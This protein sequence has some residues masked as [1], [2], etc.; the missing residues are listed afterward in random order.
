MTIHQLHYALY[1]S[2]A[3]ALEALHTESAS[4]AAAAQAHSAAVASLHTSVSELSSALELS[5]SE[6]ARLEA[7]AE[8]SQQ[9]LKTEVAHL[10]CQMAAQT[11]ALQ[12]ARDAQVSVRFSYIISS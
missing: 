7:Q 9:L 6:F 4:A 5:R 11:A 1:A 3:V 8:Q 10:E 12:E 2:Q